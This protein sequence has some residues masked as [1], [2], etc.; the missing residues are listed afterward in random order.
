[1]ARN[2]TTTNF[3]CQFNESSNIR[4]GE[5]SGWRVYANLVL[6]D[7]ASNWFNSF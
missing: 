2:T 7:T 3:S 1:M 6:N 4:K 5:M